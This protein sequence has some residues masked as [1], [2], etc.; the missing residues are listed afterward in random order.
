VFVVVERGRSRRSSRRR[1]KRR[2]REKVGTRQDDAPKRFRIVR[3]DLFSPRR[4]ERQRRGLAR[5]VRHHARVQTTEFVPKVVRLEPRERDADLEVQLLPRVDGARLI[6]VGEAQVSHRRLDGG[7]GDRA[8]LGAAHGRS[9]SRL[10]AHHGHARVHHL[11]AYVLAFAV[12]VQ[13]QDELRGAA[14]FALEVLHHP[15]APGCLLLDHGR[16]EQR[17]GVHVPALEPRGE[18]DGEDVP[19][20]RGDPEVAQHAV[21]SPREL[22]HVQVASPRDVLPVRQEGRDGRRERGFLGDA[23]HQGAAVA[24]VHRGGDREAPVR[25]RRPPRATR[26]RPRAL[27]RCSL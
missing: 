7:L 26:M 3:G 25:R 24:V 20:H 9:Q 6:D 22:V 27:S 18:V 13:P 10:G 4:D 23:H 21:V 17:G 12:A 2:R 5:P 14:R 1:R 15:R 11:E 8:E 16:V 19:G